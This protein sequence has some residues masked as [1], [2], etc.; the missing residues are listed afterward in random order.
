MLSAIVKLAPILLTLVCLL[1]QCKSSDSSTPVTPKS[2]AKSIDNPAVDGFTGATTSFDAP[3]N[4]Y[5]LTVPG[6]TDITTLKFTFTLSTGATATPNSGS[7]QNFTNPVIYTVTAEDGSKQTFTVR[8]VYKSTWSTSEARY[9]A[10][11]LK[12]QRVTGATVSAA[13]PFGFATNVPITDADVA[14]IANTA[15]FVKSYTDAKATNWQAIDKTKLEVFY[16]SLTF[17]TGEIR[18]D[19]GTNVTFDSKGNFYSYKPVWA[20]FYSK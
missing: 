16:V 12:A 14:Y 15:D 17:A 4:S 3:T 9:D 20:L 7:V 2:S 18:V 10:I 1:T 13:V 11:R 8:A 19:K 6:G 5:T